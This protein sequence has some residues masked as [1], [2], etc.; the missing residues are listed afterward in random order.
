MNT[1]H[2]YLPPAWPR[3][4]GHPDDEHF[5][6]RALA[7]LLDLAPAQ[8]RDHTV[9]RAQPLALARL[10]THSLA[11]R[12]R[13][14]E[15]TIS[16]LRDELTDALPTSALD[17]VFDVLAAEREHCRLALVQVRLVEHVLRGGDFTEPL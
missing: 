15:V 10:T 1:R 11:A 7:W 12:G 3:Q 16:R 17:E 13:G 6:R 2:G 5:A 4:V 14:A 9:L 8:Y